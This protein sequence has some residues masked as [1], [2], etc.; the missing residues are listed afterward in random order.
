MMNEI[1]D[2]PNPVA[3]A[4]DGDVA[5]GATEEPVASD[6]P[7]HLRC[8]L[9]HA[10]GRHLVVAEWAATTRRHASAVCVCVVLMVCSCGVWQQKEGCAACSP[11]K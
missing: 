3:P 9:L 6:P 11:C 1:E 4:E 7:R 5:T 10:A 2:T 8:V